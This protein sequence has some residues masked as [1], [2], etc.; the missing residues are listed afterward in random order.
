MNQSDFLDTD[1]LRI[2][3]RRRGMNET[4][5]LDIVTDMFVVVL[6]CMLG[7]PAGCLAL[8]VFTAC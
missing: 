6:S 2:L 4:A 8:P 7:G 1:S 5:R 3:L